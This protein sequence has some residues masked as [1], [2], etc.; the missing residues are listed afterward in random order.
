MGGNASF[1]SQVV[2]VK[3]ESIAVVGVDVWQLICG[4]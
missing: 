2:K 1:V 4:N 3:Q